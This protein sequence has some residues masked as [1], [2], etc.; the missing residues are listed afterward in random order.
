MPFYTREAWLLD[1]RK[2]KEWLDLLP[3]MSSTGIDPVWWT[4]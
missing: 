1:E 3:T 4:P 2:L